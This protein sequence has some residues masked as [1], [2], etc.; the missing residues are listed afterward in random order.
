MPAPGADGVQLSG[1]DRSVPLPCRIQFLFGGFLNQ[2]GWFWFGF[3]SIHL[4]VFW[5]APEGA[6]PVY[7]VI[8]LFPLIGLCLIAAGLRKGLRGLRLLRRGMTAE[9]RFI[10]KKAT[11]TKINEQTVWELSYEFTTA[12]GRTAVAKARNHEIEAL[13]DQSLEPLVYDP[14]DPS[15]A[16]MLDDLPGRPRL[17]QDSVT[18]T[19][20]S[21]RAP[22]L[23]AVPALTFFGHLAW[24]LLR[25]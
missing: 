1:P 21:L 23:L 16:V 6:W 20:G 22:L 18:R 10:G 13:T 14:L 24:T 19:E 2:F 7:F 3:S 8:T 12:S 25:R 5:G 15:N 9:G 4:R 17:D 11:N